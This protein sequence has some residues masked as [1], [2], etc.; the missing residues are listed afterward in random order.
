[1]EILVVD[2]EKSLFPEK[3]SKFTYLTRRTQKLI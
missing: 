1:M 3:G 2:E